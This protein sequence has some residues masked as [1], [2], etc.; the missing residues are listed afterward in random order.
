[1]VTVSDYRVAVVNV[2]NRAEALEQDLYNISAV[3][4][5]ALI[6]DIQ[7]AHLKVTKATPLHNMTAYYREIMQDV[8]EGLASA[9][10]AAEAAIACGFRFIRR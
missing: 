2:Q 7:R 10:K 6:A 3:E 9:D 1:M 8:A 4:I 5:R